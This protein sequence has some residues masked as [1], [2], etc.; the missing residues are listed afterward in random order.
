MARHLRTGPAIGAI[1]LLAAVADIASAVAE[2]TQSDPYR[3]I[4]AVLAHLLAVPAAVYL[5]W[6]LGAIN[7]NIAIA[8]AAAGVGSLG[9]WSYAVVWDHFELEVGWI[10]LAAG[11]WLGAGVLLRTMRPRLGTFTV[12]LGIAAVLDAIV[13]GLGDKLPFLVFALFGG[14]KLPLALVWTVW[15]GIVLLRGQLRPDT[16]QGQRQLPAGY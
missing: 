11:W 9:L 8:S 13:S 14:W 4:V 5:G 16:S 3:P 15:L 7:R 10:I 1:T 12:V 2:N 6:A